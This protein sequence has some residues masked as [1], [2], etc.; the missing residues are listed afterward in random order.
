MFTHME[1]SRNILLRS[2]VAILNWLGHND[3]K[4]SLGL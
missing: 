1:L 2:A 4:G 3:E